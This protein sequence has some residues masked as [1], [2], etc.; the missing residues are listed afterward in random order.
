MF[1]AVSGGQVGLPRT[2]VM[3]AS[4]SVRAAGRPQ[5]RNTTP[6]C[7]PE[8]RGDAAGAPA[9]RCACALS[10]AVRAPAGGAPAALPI[11]LRISRVKGSQPR[12][13][14]DPAC[15]AFTVRHALSRSTPWCAQPSRHP[16]VG[17]R[18]S[19]NSFAS[20]L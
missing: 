8:A 17:R 2:S 7:G 10:M 9:A 12:L 20:S 14:C 1:S 16:C 4:A 19:G 3:P 13:W 6:L 15:P 5:A 18:K 11:V